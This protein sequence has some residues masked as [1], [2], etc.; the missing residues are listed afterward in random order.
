MSKRRVLRGGSCYLVTSYVRT[1][2]RI[3]DCPEVRYRNYGFR[4]VIR[5]VRRE[6]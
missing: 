1:P 5:R 4:V 3:R 6:I 2:D